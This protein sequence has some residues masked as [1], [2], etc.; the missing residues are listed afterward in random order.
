MHPEDPL[1]RIRYISLALLVL[2]LLALSV[3]AA[4][5]A[6]YNEAIRDCNDDGQLQGT[7]TPRQIRDAIKHLPASLREYS[8][9]SAVLRAYLANRHRP[10]GG[11][12]TGPA[13]NP[14]ANP[15]LTTP[16]GAIASSQAEFDALKEQTSRSTDERAPVVKVGDRS[17]SPGTAGLANTAS[18]T[19]PNE[20]P[21]PVLLA[22]AG[23]AAMGA[24]AGVLVM[25]HRWP[26]TRRVALRILRR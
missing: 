8:D 25:R 4:Q 20:L 12:G 22:L 11:N 6:K 23:L 26:E 15:A 14:P 9:C 13:A 17:I 19:T 3:P 7:Y 18:R 24:L 21:L 10:N 1:S 5:A 2:A 16:S